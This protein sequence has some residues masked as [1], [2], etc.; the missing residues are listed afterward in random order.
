MP[1]LQNKLAQ[2]KAQV[3][4]LTGDLQKAHDDKERMA[5][6]KSVRILIMIIAISKYYLNTCVKKEVHNFLANS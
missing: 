6:E 2:A 3:D 4:K 5:R 1:I